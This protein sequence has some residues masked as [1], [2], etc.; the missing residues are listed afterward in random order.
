MEYTIVGYPSDGPTLELD[1]REFAYAGKFVMSS[2]GKS[3]ATEGDVVGAVAFNA[4]RD[5]PGTGHLRYVTVREDRKG[6]GIGSRLLRFTADALEGDTYD[7]VTIAVNNPLAYRACYSAGFRYCGRETGI[8]ELVMEYDPTGARKSSRYNDGLA[9][10]QS[11]DLPPEQRR[12][13]E[14]TTVPD[15]VAVPDQ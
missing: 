5:S 13:L 12:V 8:A 2:T 14:R 7:T 3:V 1:Y 6:E 10:F 11:R 15:V 4:D 9:V